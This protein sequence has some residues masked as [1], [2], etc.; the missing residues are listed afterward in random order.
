MH[1]AARR[2]P[3]KQVNKAVLAAARHPVVFALNERLSPGTEF[4]CSGSEWNRVAGRGRSISIGRVFLLLFFLVLLLTDL[5]LSRIMVVEFDLADET[6]MFHASEKWFESLQNAV[7]NKGVVLVADSDKITMTRGVHCKLFT[8]IR[9]SHIDAGWIAGHTLDHLDEHQVFQREH[10]EVAIA[11]GSNYPVLFG[12]LSD[13]ESG[14]VVDL[15]AIE[16]KH[17]V[18]VDLFNPVPV[19]AHD[20]IVTPM[21]VDLALNRDALLYLFK[22]LIDGTHRFLCA[23]SWPSYVALF[24]CR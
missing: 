1:Q 13:P 19:V 20:V 9:F 8:A 11:A 16:S 22:A 4:L 15:A 24:V 14:D 10:S 18:G 7:D 21:R 6:T 23:C 5:L 2:G 3:S 12:A 17:H